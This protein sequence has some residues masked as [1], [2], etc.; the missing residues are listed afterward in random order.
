VDVGDGKVATITVRATVTVA[1]SGDGWT[2][3]A[4]VEQTRPDGSSTAQM[5]PIPASATRMVVEP[6][7]PTATPGF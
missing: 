3:E 7:A 2:G 5:G 6:M 4:S 1:S